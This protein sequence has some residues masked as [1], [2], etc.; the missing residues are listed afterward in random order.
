ME[1]KVAHFKHYIIVAGIH[2]PIVLPI[3]RQT[4]MNTK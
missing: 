2:M 1:T 3:I 4:D